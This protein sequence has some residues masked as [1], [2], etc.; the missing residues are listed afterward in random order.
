LD[1]CKPAYK[2]FSSYFNTLNPRTP[3]SASGMRIAAY[4]DI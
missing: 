2:S 4:R 3:R 1:I